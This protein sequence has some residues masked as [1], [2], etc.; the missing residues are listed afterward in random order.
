MRFP[1]QKVCLFYRR[2]YGY[3]VTSAINVEIEPDIQHIDSSWSRLECDSD[4]IDSSLDLNE[5]AEDI[6]QVIDGFCVARAIKGYLG[7]DDF[8]DGIIWWTRAKLGEH[9]QESQDIYFAT[10]RRLFGE[11]VLEKARLAYFL[12][13][14]KSRK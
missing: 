2:K 10:I 1:V 12:G 3:P 6:W 11:E 9:D 8:G 13:E 5:N 14:K 7:M 4:E